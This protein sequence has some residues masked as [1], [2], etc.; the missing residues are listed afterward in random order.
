VFEVVVAAGFWLHAA[1]LAAT[2][3]PSDN[4]VIAKDLF[5]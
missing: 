3:R 1:M 4:F 5:I 2:N